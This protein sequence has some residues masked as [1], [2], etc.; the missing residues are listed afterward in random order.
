VITG[1]PVHVIDLE[2]EHKKGHINY[3]LV[4]ADFTEMKKAFN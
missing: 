2:E 3:G 4:E 1:A